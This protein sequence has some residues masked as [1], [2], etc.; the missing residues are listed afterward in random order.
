MEKV[1]FVKIEVAV[2]YDEDDIPNDFPFRKNNILSLIVEHPKGKIVNFPLD[3]KFNSHWFDSL[4]IDTKMDIINENIFNLEMKVTDQGSYYLLDENMNELAAI[5][6]N[7]VPDSY[8]IPGEFGDYINFKINI[9]T[10]FIENW[11]GEKATF[12][13]FNIKGDT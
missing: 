13:E 9:K 11:Y 5:E 6:E 3:Y 7:Y 12:K 1:K 2:R 10:G 4:P 8:S